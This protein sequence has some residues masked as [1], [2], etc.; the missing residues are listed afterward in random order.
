MNT[1]YVNTLQAGINRLNWAE[2]LN[3]GLYKQASGTLRKG[4]NHFC[5]LGV[6]CELQHKQGEGSWIRTEG[7]WTY[8]FEEED[9]CGSAPNLFIENLGYTGEYPTGE[10]AADIVNGAFAALNDILGWSFE[11]IADKILQYPSV[12]EMQALNRIAINMN[13]VDEKRK[14][15]LMLQAAQ[16]AS[17]ATLDSARAWPQA[18]NE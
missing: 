14:E 10:T 17:I 13:Y 8:I 15:E 4:P 18:D 2:A 3:S 6:L 7:V 11:M 1:P 12:E 9:R 16:E 5:C